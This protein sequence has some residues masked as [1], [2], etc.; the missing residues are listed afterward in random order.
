MNEFPAQFL[1]G[2]PPNNPQKQ[3]ED[4]GNTTE[5]MES[6]FILGYFGAISR[7][8]TRKID[9]RC[10][11]EVGN[12]YLIS[13]VAGLACTM[14]LC[15]YKIRIPNTLYGVTIFHERRERQT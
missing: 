5:G 12:Q 1:P 15:M 10:K 8:F 9:F 2:T 11:C 6:L 7:W 4:K 14:A 13:C 3:G